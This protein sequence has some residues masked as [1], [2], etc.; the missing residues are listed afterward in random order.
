MVEMIMTRT[1][2]RCDELAAQGFMVILPDYF[3]GDVP[4]ECGPGDFAC[5]GGTLGTPNLGPRHIMQTIGTI[6]F[7]L[8]ALVPIMAANTNWTRLEAD[9]NLVRSWAEEKGVTTFAAVGEF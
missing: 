1:R 6:L 9:W 7:F 8:P 5:W 3:R 2:E 4:E